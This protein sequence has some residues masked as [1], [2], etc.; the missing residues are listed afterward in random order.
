MRS[1]KKKNSHSIIAKE[2]YKPRQ[3]VH[4]YF[5]TVLLAQVTALPRSRQKVSSKTRTKKLFTL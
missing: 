4:N 2:W 1:K 5:R 3:K